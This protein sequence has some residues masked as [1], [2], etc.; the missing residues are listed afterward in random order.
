LFN[1]CLAFLPACAPGESKPGDTDGTSSGESGSSGEAT[2]LTTAPESSESTTDD[3]ATST[4]L[5]TSETG[6]PGTCP[7]GALCG[8]EPPEGWFGP[9]IIA[10][11]P[12]G[13]AAPACPEEIPEA[14]PIL[15]DGFSDPPPAVCSCECQPPASPSCDANLVVRGP[16]SCGGFYDFINVESTC[17][18]L[19]VDSFAEFNLYGYYYYYNPPMCMAEQSAEIPPIAWE[20]TINTCRLSETPLSC[21]GGGVCIPPAPE[22]FEATW[23]IYQQGDSGC[24][25]GVFNTKSLVFS[26]AVDT[27]E[28]GDCTCGSA[29][30]QC[31]G[32][33]LMVFSEPDCAGTPDA[34]L[35]ANGPC[36]DLTAASF[37]VDY[38]ASGSCPVSSPP[39]SMGAAEPTGEFTFCCAG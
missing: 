35:P 37:A 16:N 8:S 20:S 39:Q 6:E 11:V 25:A 10:R 9:T 36:S 28:C 26:G 31:E 27:R 3:P 23:C 33:E 4:S 15:F 32:A 7:E 1:G 34:F 38:P 21:E 17:T 5:D 22:G 24:P 12:N 2:T 13:E 18:N 14:G 30:N 29:G 19:D